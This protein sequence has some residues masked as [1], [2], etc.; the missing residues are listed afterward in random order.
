MNI[1]ETDF[2][3]PNFTQILPARINDR[4]KKAFARLLREHGLT[5]N[6]NEVKLEVKLGVKIRKYRVT[7]SIKRE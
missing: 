1:D 2:K 4:L 3:I 7:I 5:W 6:E